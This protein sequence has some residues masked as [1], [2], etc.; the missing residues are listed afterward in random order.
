MSDDPASDPNQSGQSGSPEEV[1][2]GAFNEGELDAMLLEASS[3]ASEL[4]EEARSEVTEKA[5]ADQPPDST[6]EPGDA[7]SEVDAQLEEMEQ[8]LHAASGEVAEQD[9]EPESSKEPQAEPEPIAAMDDSL[10]P[11][12]G[13]E[14]QQSAEESPPVPEAGITLSEQELTLVGE[15]PGD[16]AIPDFGDG[17]SL[18][19]ALAVYTPSAAPTVPTATNGSPDEVHPPAWLRRAG[20]VLAPLS[21]VGLR[22]CGLGVKGLEALDRYLQRIPLFVKRVLGYLAL[23]TAGVACLVLLISLF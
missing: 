16:S 1:T 18:E 8:L 11:D 21:P 2:D 15:A 22:V 10:A 5:A 12:A 6:A 13:K 3:L 9:E 14:E 19:P 23:A 7:V 4:A 17:S 20:R